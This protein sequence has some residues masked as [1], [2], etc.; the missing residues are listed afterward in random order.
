MDSYILLIDC[1]DEKGLI[2]KI[3][4]VIYKYDLNVISNGEFV[5]RKENRFFMRTEFSGSIDR[6]R[7]LLSLYKVL[8]EGVHIKLVPHQKKKNCYT[9]NE[10]TPLPCGIISAPSF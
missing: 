7:L 8:P 5:D 1:K 6:E 4:E 10:R 3:T 9:R 2:Y